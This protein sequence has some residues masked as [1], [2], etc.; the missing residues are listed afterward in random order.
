MNQAYAEILEEGEEVVMPKVGVMIEVPSLA[1]MA[2]VIAKEVDFFSIGTNDLTQSTFSFS[3]EDAENKFL[4]FYNENHI[5]QDNPFEVLDT[6]RV[7]KLIKMAVS[8]G[9]EQ[10][11][12]L[13][14]GMV[15]FMIN[16]PRCPAEFLH[17]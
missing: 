7:G 16:G 15:N 3:R 5:L 17:E 6:K 1:I 4:P 11:K 14:I 8:S 10:R 13:N 12:D 2:D 9:L